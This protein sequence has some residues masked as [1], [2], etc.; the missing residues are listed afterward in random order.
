MRD[1]LQ[2]EEIG[3]EL[4]SE[5][6]LAGLWMRSGPWR[7]SLWWWFIILELEFGLIW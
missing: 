4:E 3:L 2:Y 6:C 1:F 5:W 7:G